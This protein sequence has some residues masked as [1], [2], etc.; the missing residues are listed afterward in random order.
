MSTPMTAGPSTPGTAP[1][2][3]RTR[4][5]PAGPPARFTDLLAAEWIKLRS[6]R[7]IPWFVLFG[8]VVI[9]G[10][11]A[12]GAR[13][14][15]ADWPAWPAARQAYYARFGALD[16]AF[17][18]PAAMSMLLA[19]G[20]LGAIAILSEQTTGLLRTTFAAVPA[21]REVMAAKTVVVCAVA[22]GFGAFVVTVSFWLDEAILAG[23]YGGVGIGDPG[24][25]RFVLASGLLA[26]VG[27]LVGLGLG[28]VIRHAVTAM[29]TLFVLVFVLPSFVHD[30]TYAGAV[31]SHALPFPA[32]SC[33]ILPDG[34][35]G[36]RY[37][38]TAG[39]SWTVYALWTAV[40]VLLA[41]AV[42]PRRDQ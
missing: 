35:H 41:L 38:A 13:S 29:V 23:R 20:A 18:R 22:T 15:R 32:W 6:L 42:V 14:A 1:A 8:T 24:T 4:Q 7:S 34:M 10:L 37:P 36:M 19:M 28:A 11:N 5:V 3:P 40:A 17:T 31:V 9:V 33:L 21:R 27:A 25:L 2:G 30:D 16:D 39:G 26:P 12:N